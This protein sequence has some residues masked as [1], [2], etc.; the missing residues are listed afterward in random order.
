MGT[1]A[2]VVEPV[3]PAPLEADGLTEAPAVQQVQQ[4]TRAILW[5]TFMH[6]EGRRAAQ[7]PP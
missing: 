6:L 7:L 2:G 5:L 1:A 3:Q 4:A